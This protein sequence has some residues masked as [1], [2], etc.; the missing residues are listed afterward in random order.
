MKNNS[1]QAHNDIFIL[2]Q[3]YKYSLAYYLI[4]LHIIGHASFSMLHLIFHADKF[5]NF[6]AIQNNPYFI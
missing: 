5:R 2:K 3:A 1:I 4:L 6:W